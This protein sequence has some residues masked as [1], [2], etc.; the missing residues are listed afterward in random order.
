[1]NLAEATEIFDRSLSPQHGI[2]TRALWGSLCLCQGRLADARRLLAEA[3][4]VARQFDC[5]AWMTGHRGWLAAL[6]TTAEQD[7]AKAMDLYQC[8]CKTFGDAGTRWWWARV[9][10]DWAEAHAIRGEPGDRE[11]AAELLR[12][13]HQAFQDMGVPRYAAVARERLHELESAAE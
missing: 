3:N 7:W 6:V 1:V 13:A 2:Q 10:L 9:R 5:S 11:R 4:E 8:T 12:E